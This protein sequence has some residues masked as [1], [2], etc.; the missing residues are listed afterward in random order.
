MPGPVVTGREIVLSGHILPGWKRFSPAA[1]PTKCVVFVTEVCRD[2]SHLA[3]RIRPSEFFL[4]RSMPVH[5]RR[6]AKFPGGCEPAPKQPIGRGTIVQAAVV[7]ACC[8]RRFVRCPPAAD[9]GGSASVAAPSEAASARGTV[10]SMDRRRRARLRSAL[11]A[12]GAVGDQG[13]GVRQMRW[14]RRRVPTRSGSALFAQVG[15]DRRYRRQGRGCPAERSGVGVGLRLGRRQQPT[16][17]GEPTPEGSDRRCDSWPPAD[18]DAELEDHG[19]RI[20]ACSESPLGFL[21][22]LW[23]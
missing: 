10:R 20:V 8:A 5:P 18:V 9:V 6:A 7:R 22:K 2:I 4:C 17:L 11:G 15:A 3:A 13:L 23:P 12:I 1:E 19:C 14:A 16:T 21:P